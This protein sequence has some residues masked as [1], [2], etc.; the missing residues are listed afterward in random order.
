VKSG[1]VFFS[2]SAAQASEVQNIA[3]KNASRNRAIFIA[4]FSAQVV[5]F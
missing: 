4:L 5:K 3:K 2:S 1:A